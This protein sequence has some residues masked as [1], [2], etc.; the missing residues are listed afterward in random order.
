MDIFK[1][2]VASTTGDDYVVRA[3]LRRAEGILTHVEWCL[4]TKARDDL[5]NA[6]T[7]PARVRLF[8]SSEERPN[9]KASSTDG[10]STE[11]RA[12]DD[13]TAKL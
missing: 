4:F 13:A 9:E 12:P 3:A 8:L 5:D 6:E 2:A 10:S 7:L 11:A 1:E